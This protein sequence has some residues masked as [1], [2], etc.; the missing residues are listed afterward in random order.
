MKKIEID[1]ENLLYR[2]D[3]I[4]GNF[5]DQGEEEWA[6]VIRDTMIILEQKT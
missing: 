1:I 2:L 4:Y 3:E 5:L 6:T